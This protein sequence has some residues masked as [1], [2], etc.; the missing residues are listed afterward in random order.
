MGTDWYINQMRYK[1]NNSDPIDPIWSA[2][3]I[4]GANRDVVYAPES[5][6]LFGTNTAMINQFRSKAGLTN[7]PSIPMDLYTMMKDY[8]GSDDPNKMVQKQDGSF[9][10]IFPSRKVSVPVDLNL[11][12][13][14]GTVNANDSVVTE[15][16]FEIP[17]TEIYKNDAAVLNLIAAN[18]WKRP[19]YFT[20]SDA[21]GLGF[22]KYI[23]Q[24]G[25]TYRL[26]PVLNSEVNEDWVFDKM[27]NKFVFGNCNKP[28]VY[29]DEENR[30]HLNTIRQAYGIAA[31]SLA[32]NNKK[33]EAKKML[34]KCDSMMLQENFPY[35][36]VS[37]GQQHNYVS[38]IMLQASY[39][40]GDTTLSAKISKSL[41]KDFEQQLAYY[42]VLDE[43]QASNFDY[44]DQSG[45]KR[46]DKNDVE[47][48]LMQLESFEQQ[49]KAQ[50]V[51][52]TQPPT[53]TNQ[54]T[55]PLKAVDPRKKK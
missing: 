51:T 45:R 29:Y 7:D 33:E 21:A 39:F 25:L 41:R 30:R 17:K 49:F 47:R 9:I 27:M 36:L 19:I 4:E 31:M 32:Q 11:V 6:F 28:G 14:N 37:R 43:E 22:Q 50:L 12:R 38:M 2:K 35:G 3:Q 55:A 53:I 52:E 5:R 20:S 40:A 10:N 15:L 34:Q 26:V 1:L 48:F 13:Q 24:D 42:A 23:R 46:G 54:P 8:A 16:L 18:K 44:I